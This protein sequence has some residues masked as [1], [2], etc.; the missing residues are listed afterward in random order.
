[1]VSIDLTYLMGE[2]EKQELEAPNGVASPQA[3]EQL[4]AIYLYKNDLCNA[5]YLWKRIPS[6]IKES[7][8]ELGHIWSV[9]QY[10]WKKD[11][12][13]IYNALNSVTWTETVADIMKKV[14]ESVRDR[15][16]QLISQAYSSITLEAVCAMTGLPPDSC[17]KTCIDRQWQIESDSKIVH[18]V[19]S[20]AQSIGQTS[21][22][23][24]L[25]KLTDFVSFLEN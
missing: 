7:N 25:Y 16:I 18:P 4:L 2:L 21:S 10:M 24:Q 9:G 15:A 13:S 5:K 8:P 17:C 23:D 3:Y 20:D 1:M 19:L 14:Q 22:E 11:Y 12:P 6:Q